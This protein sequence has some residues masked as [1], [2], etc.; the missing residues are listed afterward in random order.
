MILGI[1]PQP[2]TKHDAIEYGNDDSFLL[3]TL[4]KTAAAGRC[5]HQAEA[6]NGPFWCHCR[7]Q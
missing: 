6:G 3:R 4:L 1:V 7:N 2:C 5:S